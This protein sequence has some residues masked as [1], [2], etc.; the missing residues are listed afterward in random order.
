MRKSP[1][2]MFTRRFRIR[3]AQHNR[4]RVSQR[5]DADR[6]PSEMERKSAASAEWILLVS[7]FV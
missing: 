5:E 6:G 3:S 1:W 7:I 4:V 2:P